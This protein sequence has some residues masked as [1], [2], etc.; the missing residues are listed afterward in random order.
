MSSFGGSYGPAAGSGGG[1][2]LTA[3]QVQALIDAANYERHH[4][5]VATVADLVTLTAAKLGDEAHV[6]ADDTTYELKG[7]DPTVAANWI[8]TTGIVTQLLTTADSTTYTADGTT[9]TADAA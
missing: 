9:V 8:A 3:A 7:A 1:G 5:L 4:G 6:T 2:G